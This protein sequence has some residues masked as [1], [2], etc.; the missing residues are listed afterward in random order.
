MRLPWKDESGFTIVELVIALMLLSVAI[1]SLAQTSVISIDA[2]TKASM[3]TTAAALS[4][5][6]MEEVKT[7]D[8]STLATESVVQIN[9][10]G[11]SD[12]MA[13]FSRTLTVD[14]LSANL[15]RVTI[16]IDYP[17]ALAPVRMET[18]IYTTTIS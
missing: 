14:S 5:S 1:F 11:D 9:E 16:E 15:S 7:R 10:W 8:P 17:K 4:K 18:I 3:R 12:S 2:Q 6:Y 13:V